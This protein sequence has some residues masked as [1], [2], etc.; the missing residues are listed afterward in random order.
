MNWTDASALCKS[1]GMNL[2][3]IETAE[4]QLLVASGLPKFDGNSHENCLFSLVLS[5]HLIPSNTRLKGL[6][7]FRIRGQRRSVDVDGY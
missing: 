5:G 2:V 1:I 7:D 6:V 4:E 3:S